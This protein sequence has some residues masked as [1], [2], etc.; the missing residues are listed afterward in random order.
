MLGRLGVT[1]QQGLGG[2]DHAGGAEA[3]LEAV[4]L[5]EAFL[6]RVHASGASNALDRLDAGAVGLDGEHRT[7][8]EGAPVHDHGAGAAA[9]GIAADVGAGEGQL[10]ADEVDEQE[11]RLDLDGVRGAVDGEG[12]GVVAH[13]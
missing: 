13:V 12:D 5:P 10:L 6:E 3:A 2:H 1:L 8:L 7:A 11:A 4:L 9:G